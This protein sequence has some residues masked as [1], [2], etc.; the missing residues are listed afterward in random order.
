MCHTN[1]VAPI[2]T[3]SPWQGKSRDTG[4]TTVEAFAQ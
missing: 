3:A 2:I 4:D 1:F